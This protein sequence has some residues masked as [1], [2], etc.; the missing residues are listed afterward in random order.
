MKRIYRPIGLAVGLIATLFCVIYIASSWRD[1]DLSA[2]ASPQAAAGLSLAIAFYVVGVAVSAE[3]WRRLLA[4]VGLHNSWW[5]L[6]GIVAV[7]QVGKYLPGNVAHHIGRASLALQRGIG[8]VP[9]AVTAGTEMLLLMLASLVVGTIALLLSGIS[10][11][12]LPVGNGV[13][14]SAIA[15]M[16]AAAVMGLLVL[17]KFGPLLMTRFA[18]QH[19]TVFRSSNLPSATSMLMAF[20]CYCIV[21]LAF[22]AG[23]VVMSG[24]LTPDVSQAPWLLVASFALA[25]TIGFVT[26]GAPA[27]LGVREG[28]M[29]FIL[30]TSY[31]PADA[32]VIVIALRLATTVGDVALLPIGWLLVRKHNRR[33][34]R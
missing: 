26:P 8:P 19:A 2:Y 15:A 23:I 9:L 22:G 16:I 20:A 28:V 13:A 18:P 11:A 24:L 30:G 31:P 14:M 3:G 32:A 27:G 1:Q 29:L 17:R 34:G 6:T 4:G 7:T 21:F 25:W 12:V 5:E 10:L 33:P